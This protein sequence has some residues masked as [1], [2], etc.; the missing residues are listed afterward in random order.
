MKS[1][2]K[3]VYYEDPKTNEEASGNLFYQFRW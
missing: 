2:E 1:T 3:I